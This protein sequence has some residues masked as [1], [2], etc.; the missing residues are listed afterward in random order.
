MAELPRMLKPVR[1]NLPVDIQIYTSILSAQ[2]SNQRTATFVLK[3]QGVL[4]PK[5]RMVFSV[6]VNDQT[7]S[8][9]MTAF[10]P[11]GIGAHSCVDRARLL[12]GTRVLSEIQNRP[13]LYG[14]MSSVH[15]SCDKKLVDMVLNG[16]VDVVANSPNTDGL[17]AV[18]ASSGIYTSSTSGKVADKFKLRKDPNETPEWSI[19]IEDLF[20]M[21]RGVMLPLQF[22]S[23]PV[24][25][26][27]EFT[28]QANNEVGKVCCFNG[29][30]P[31]DSSTFYDLNTLALQV[32]TIMFPDN[33]MDN[34]RNDV[35][36]EG[37]VMRYDDHK[38]T[39]TSID[40]LKASDVLTGTTKDTRDIREVMS[41]GLICKNVIITEEVETNEVSSLTISNGGDYS[42][43]PTP[44]VV[45]IT[46]AS[47][48]GR[49]ATGIIVAS[50][51]IKGG[52]LGALNITAA[53]SA[54]T[55]TPTL[56]IG[57]P[58]GN[59][60]VQASAIIVL[61][62]GVITSL[63]NINLGNGYLFNPTI[64]VSGGGG[65]GGVI[66]SPAVAGGSI[67]KIT[68]TNKGSGYVSSP[69]VSITGGGG[70]GGGVVSANI[71]KKTNPLL[72]VYGCDNTTHPSKINFRYNDMVVY[73]RA[74]E[75]TSLKRNEFESV[76]EHPISA[77]SV[78][79]SNDCENDFISD[80]TDKA[81]GGQNKL[82][83]ASCLF[84]GHN[85]DCLVG[86]KGYF[87]LQL[88]RSP[89]GAGTKIQNAN[90]RYERDNT[91]SFNDYEK[92]TLRF[93]TQYEKTAIIQN[94][95]IMVS[96]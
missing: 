40:G 58:T 81:N 9:N 4:S 62:G 55:S 78:I 33:Y 44:P 2:T 37:I 77:P 35:F 50:T 70:V 54:Y 6:C 79:Y 38:T 67:E 76:M 13:Q 80:L 24:S 47:G 68:L 94:G 45:S 39:I 60:P 1:T 89:R 30:A 84:E 85:P 3:N 91:Y 56:N 66:L 42:A 36:G 8:D 7:T 27:I 22:L 26:E 64:T 28:Q 25:I 52:P 82:M 21:M 90:V 92:R 57:A 83:D 65:S 18:D 16:S 43:N 87:A 71:A 20:P 75:N 5:S 88:R 48:N 86:T 51:D 61:T 69:S 73:S 74:V 12:C 93:Y 53:G 32:D 49:G 63:T 46:D 23:L 34:L 10:L 14:A 11:I 19:S 15:E 17:Y 95:E 72:G 29:D 96:A 41:A 59:N 31:A